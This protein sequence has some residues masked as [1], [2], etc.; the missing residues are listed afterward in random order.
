MARHSNPLDPAPRPPRLAEQIISLLA[1]ARD[2]SALL[3]DL[4][5]EF[6]DRVD[7]SERGAERWYWLQ[8]V[9][10]VPHLVLCRVRSSSVQRLFLALAS[11]ILAVIFMWVWDMFVSRTLA[12]WVARSNTPP[13][14]LVI[15]TL[16]FSVQ[17]LGAA[18]CGAVITWRLFAIRNSFWTN[19][20]IHLGPVILILIIMSLISAIDRGLVRS[21]AYLLMRNGLMIA[22]LVS[23]AAIT[24]RFAPKR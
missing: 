23:A 20:T 6:A 9:Q 4:S 10:S 12:Q 24:S 18:I 22:A 11:I 7:R 5:E 19:V 16:Y 21:S 3:G 17:I 8:V 13:P 14:L 2:R 15:R 1:P